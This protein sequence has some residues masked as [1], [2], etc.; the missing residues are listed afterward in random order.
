MDPYSPEGELINI[1]SAFHAGAYQ[2][3]LDFDTSNFSSSNALPVRVLQLRS[4]IA[5]GQAQA[6]SN[7]LASEKTPDLIAVKLL[8]DYEQSK[9]VLSQA[10]KLAEQHGQDNLTVQLCVGMILERAGETEAALNVLSK[11]QGSLDAVALIVQIHL[12]QNRTDLA[13]KEAQR[14][15]KWAQ[16][17]LLVNIAE[18]W[19]GM[20]EGGEKYQSAFYVFEE[21]ATSSQSTSPHS[22]VAQA[23]SELHLGRLPEAEAA[24]QQALSIDGTSADTLANLIVL[25]TLLGKKEDAE[26]LKSQL[27][28][29][30]PQH[31]A[32]ADW[33]SKKEEF[34]KAAAKYTPKFEVAS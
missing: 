16:D 23:V 22:L 1:H 25:N 30:A 15:R 33:A 2:Q 29:S 18:S 3:V 9:D 21:L 13:A 31:R 27:Q 4:Q 24:L 8:A 11:H 10:K 34:A 14:A 6:V 28:S 19:V 17:S 7:E 12:Q 32:I 26:Q 5:L 20:R